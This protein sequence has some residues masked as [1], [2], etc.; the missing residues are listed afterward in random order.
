MPKVS[1]RMASASPEWVYRLV[2]R[3]IK[4]AGWEHEPAVP[5]WEAQWEVVGT[6]QKGTFSLHDQDAK[7]LREGLSEEEA[8]READK[9]MVRGSVLDHARD[10]R[11]GDHRTSS[12]R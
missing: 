8:L 5:E 2:K 4:P 12:L 10:Q 6:G 7:W 1:F 9:T 3:M 11:E